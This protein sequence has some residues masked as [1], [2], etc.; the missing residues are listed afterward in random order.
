MQDIIPPDGVLL[1]L[2]AETL[3]AA[4]AQISA[5]VAEITG[6]RAPAIHQALM[7][8]IH[9]GVGLGQGAALPHVRLAG[10]RR[11]LA[12]FARPVVPILHSDGSEIRL[13][14]VLFAPE[15]ADA[16]H[17]KLLAQVAGVLRNEQ[18]RARLL[19]G[20]REDIYDLLTAA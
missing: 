7:A 5:M 11:T 12:F 18:S 1:H 13:L 16:A 20:G 8:R 9:L 3:D 10:L 6:L 4:M 15:D 19:Q 17:L 14:F 2:K